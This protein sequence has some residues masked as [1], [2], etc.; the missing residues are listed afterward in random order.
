VT[1]ESL[2]Q[3]A[4]RLPKWGAS[5]SKNFFNAAVFFFRRKA[6]PLE[7]GML[8]SRAMLAIASAFE[9]NA[10][11]RELGSAEMKDPIRICVPMFSELHRVS[12]SCL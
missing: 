9:F 1:P 10:T 11:S 6:S 3:P 2:D 7:A 12:C 5:K 8:L 4:G